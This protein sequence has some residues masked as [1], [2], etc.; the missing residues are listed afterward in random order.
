VLAEH[1]AF[2]QLQ[3]QQAEEDRRQQLFE[4]GLQDRAQEQQVTPTG[5]GQLLPDA[6]TLGPSRGQVPTQQRKELQ[7]LA[8]F[9][10]KQIAKARA[11]GKLSDE[12]FQAI[13]QEFTNRYSTLSLP[14]PVDLYNAET[15]AD[16]PQVKLARKRE[17][18]RKAPWYFEGLE[19]TVDIDPETGKIDYT[20][21]N[22]A[23]KY[24][25]QQARDKREQD[26][27]LF[28]SQMKTIDERE[29]ALDDIV[30]GTEGAVSQEDFVRNKIR[31]V[32]ERRELRNQFLG[33]E[34]QAGTTSEVDPELQGVVQ[35]IQSSRLRAQQLRIPAVSS[36]AEYDSLDPGA[37]FI[38]TSDGRRYKKPQ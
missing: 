32:N 24:H 19:D 5:L 38:D 3:N 28:E 7:G 33:I 2:T 18:I 36:Q 31:Y 25:T 35:S 1:I 17:S 9:E 34:Q 10:W 23:V 11:E 13:T 22:E 8:D 21:Y 27:A 4:L 6:F 30:K 15:E 37:E 14:P 12:N 20:A 16:N 26:I 29:R